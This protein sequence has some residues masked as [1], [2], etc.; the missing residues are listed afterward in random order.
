[1]KLIIALVVF[2][3]LI[4]AGIGIFIYIKGTVVVE[5]PTNQNVTL[6][7]WGLWEDKAIVQP[8]I[9]EYQAANPKV[10]ISYKTQSREG[11]RE[12][13]TNTIAKGE[14]PD[15]FRLHNTWV[16]MFQTELSILPATVM[17][18]N[19]FRRTFYPVHTADLTTQ[20]GIVGIP[21][22][23]DG[24]ALFINED[25]FTLFA[26]P[27]PARW[28]QFRETAKRLTI[29]PGN[30]DFQQAGAAMG[31]AGNI[32]HW[33]EILSLLILQN[34]GDPGDP[35]TNNFIN[36]LAYYR[37]FAKDNVWSTTFPSSTNAFANGKLAMYFGP[38]W[39]IFDIQAVNPNLNF[40]VVPVPQQLKEDP[41]DPDIT[42]ATYWFEGVW[43]RS[44]NALV[45]WE[46]LKFMSTKESLEKLFANASQ[47]RSFGEPYPR[48]EMRE[49]LLTNSQ[50]SPFMQL[51]PN[52]KSWYLASRTFDGETGLNS[53][54]SA[55]FG[56][57][58]NTGDTRALPANIQEV[59]TQYGIQ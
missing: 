58:V 11:Y 7:W 12:R 5:E 6:T 15:I 22:E 10:T 43:A 49:S 33:P 13:L 18:Q 41:N 2:L 47:T 1:M 46:F 52:A 9:D 37:N 29:N 36:A 8:L 4:A 20:A 28:T 45:A 38:S 59:L 3:A 27:V 26:E 55:I 19:E 16:P 17:S 39:R 35:T 48:I 44:P 53:Q 25:I 14:G 32:D 57:A 40:K 30:K 50:L 54:L 34:G 24:L 23:Y 51:A 42:Y 31:T 21:L 56:E